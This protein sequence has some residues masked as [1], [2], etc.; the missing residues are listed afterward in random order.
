MTFLQTV[1]LFK[2]LFQ[3]ST[4]LLER[5]DGFLHQYIQE[6]VSGK[7]PTFSNLRRLQQS[8]ILQT[9]FDPTTLLSGPTWLGLLT[10]VAKVPG[11]STDKPNLNLL[12]EAFKD[13]FFNQSEIRYLSCDKEVFNLLITLRNEHNTYNNQAEKVR[14]LVYHHP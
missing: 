5:N 12:E 11:L 10:S 3:I 4:L 6:M 9:M 7:A 8:T 14:N 13:T 1:W 2:F